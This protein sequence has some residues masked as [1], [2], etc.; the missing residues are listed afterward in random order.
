MDSVDNRERDSGW[1][2]G[3]QRVKGPSTGQRMDE[4]TETP[5]VHSISREE[6]GRA[7]SASR[8]ID[9]A[10]VQRKAPKNKRGARRSSAAARGD[11]NQN[12]LN[13]YACFVFYPECL[14]DFFLG[15]GGG[16]EGLF[17]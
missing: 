4:T 1:M 2:P 17:F 9:R 7:E 6:N 11:Q 10:A 16:G 14:R 15:G 5:G 8:E 13:A 3:C 12:H